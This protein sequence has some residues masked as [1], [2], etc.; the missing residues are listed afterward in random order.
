MARAATSLGAWELRS[1]KAAGDGTGF[2]AVAIGCAVTKGL[3]SRSHKQTTSAFEASVDLHRSTAV[4]SG[5]TSGFWAPKDR[6]IASPRLRSP[7]AKT[8]A[9]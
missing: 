7:A 3:L 8:W 2:A 1:L 9:Y 5:R 6:S 4:A